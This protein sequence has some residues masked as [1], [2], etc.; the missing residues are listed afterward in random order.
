[1]S[2]TCAGMSVSG[3]AGSRWAFFKPGSDGLARNSKDALNTAQA[4]TFIIGGEDLLLLLFGV[5]H[6]WIEHAA[7]GAVFAPILLLALGIVSVLHNALT[8]AVGQRSVTIL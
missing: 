3:R 5:T 7:F 2:A 4:R 6:V 1:M 8:V